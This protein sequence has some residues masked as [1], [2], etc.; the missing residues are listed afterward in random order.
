MTWS[1]I[2]QFI[3]EGGS[4]GQPHPHICMPLHNI[5]D[6]KKDILTHIKLD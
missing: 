3:D 4:V 1:E 2:K 6:I 5:S